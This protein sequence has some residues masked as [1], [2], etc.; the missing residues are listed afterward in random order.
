MGVV[1][2]FLVSSEADALSY[3]LEWK[4]SIPMRSV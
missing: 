4:Q 1:A 3:A 2:D